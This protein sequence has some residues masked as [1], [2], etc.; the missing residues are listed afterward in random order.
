MADVLPQAFDAGRFLL[1]P[2]GGVHAPGQPLVEKKLRQNRCE[3][4]V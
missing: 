2:R 4:R 1:H 3:G